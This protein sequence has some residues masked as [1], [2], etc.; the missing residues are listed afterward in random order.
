MQPH[1]IIRYRDVLCICVPVPGNN[2]VAVTYSIVDAV[3][4][5][6]H[7][8]RQQAAVGFRQCYTGQV[9]RRSVVRLDNELRI[10][11]VRRSGICF[12]EISTMSISLYVF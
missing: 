4:F 1:I 3:F 12:S 8:K 2:L 6:V 7:L 9:L 5:P 11:D 10:S